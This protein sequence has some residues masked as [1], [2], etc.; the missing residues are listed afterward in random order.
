M[1]VALVKKKSQWKTKELETQTLDQYLHTWLS[2]G[3][4]SILMSIIPIGTFASA[5]T[6]FS[7]MEFRK[8]PPGE[9]K[10]PLHSRKCEPNKWASPD[11]S[12]L[13]RTICILSVEASNIEASG[14]LLFWLEGFFSSSKNP[15]GWIYLIFK[16]LLWPHQGSHPR[17]TEKPYNGYVFEV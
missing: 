14:C 1:K 11:G 2:L 12:V 7:S 4:K 15:M 16:V 5:P 3:I 9:H 17:V 6:P 13:M 10:I 8:R